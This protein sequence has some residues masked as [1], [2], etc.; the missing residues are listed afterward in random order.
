MKIVW[1]ILAVLVLAACEPKERIVTVY[2]TPEINIPIVEKPRSISVQTVET[3]LLTKDVMVKL[4]SDPQYQTMV[5]MSKD[6]YQKL[7]NN[8]LEAI[9]YIETQDKVIVYYEKTIREIN[10]Q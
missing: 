6:A 7:V 10:E 8:I 4:S 5:G 9:R 3:T 2:E 1:S